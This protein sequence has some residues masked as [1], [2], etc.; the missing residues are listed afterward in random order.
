VLA[1]KVP[2]NW[3]ADGQHILTLAGGT[4]LFLGQALQFWRQTVGNQRVAALH[5]AVQHN[6]AEILGE[7]STAQK[8]LDKVVGVI[9]GRSDRRLNPPNT[10]PPV[11]AN[12]GL[13]RR[14]TD[15]P[16]S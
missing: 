2:A 10:P 13:G 8:S 9:S 15:Q 3:F 5:R 1:V 14:A 12:G 7:L 6:D 4:L 16:A 11:W